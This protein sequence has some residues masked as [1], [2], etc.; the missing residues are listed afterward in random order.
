VTT[1][2]ALVVLFIE[3]IWLSV[4][5]S[6]QKNSSFSITNVKGE[7]GEQVTK[8]SNVSSGCCLFWTSFFN[9]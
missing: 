4:S 9:A 2:L 8:E 7:K 5:T 3:F 6:R 1:K